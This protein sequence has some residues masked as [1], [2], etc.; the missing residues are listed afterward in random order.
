MKILIFWEGNKSPAIVKGFY[1]LQS[2]LQNANDMG[3]SGKFELTILNEKE[4]AEED[5]K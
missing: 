5:L 2:W 3:V 4:K 1:E